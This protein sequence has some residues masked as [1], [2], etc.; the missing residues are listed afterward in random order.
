M[1]RL[2]RKREQLLDE[3]ELLQTSAANEE[4]PLFSGFSSHGDN[5]WVCIIP[6][7]SLS[8]N[9]EYNL[10]EKTLQGRAMDVKLQILKDLC[11]DAH[12]T[13]GVIQEMPENSS[14]FVIT[15][16]KGHLKKNLGDFYG[17][18][19]WVEYGFRQCKQELGWT[20]YRVTHFQHIER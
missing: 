18:R 20:D 8:E 4:N 19:T 9:K 6:L 13:E 15:N 11:R 5:P 17:L 3:P 1:L 14:S 10:K 16:L 2:F 7:M 12:P